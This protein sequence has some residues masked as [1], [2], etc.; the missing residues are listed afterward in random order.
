M[1]V[2]LSELKNAKVESLT[3]VYHE[4]MPKKFFRAKSAYVDRKLTR[5]EIKVWKKTIENGPKEYLV[6]FDLQG[7]ALNN[8]KRTDTALVHRHKPLYSIQLIG[9]WPEH[10]LQA[11]N[12]DYAE[13]YFEKIDKLLGDEAFQN[14]ID[15]KVGS[16]HKYYAENYDKLKQVK[17]KY[18]PEN[19]FQYKQSIPLP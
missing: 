12:E 17:A 2:D 3:N 6:L 1:I 18:D 11:A 7:G 14:Y 16:A 8:K 15:A 13:T 10:N 9:D 5:D 4:L 19:W